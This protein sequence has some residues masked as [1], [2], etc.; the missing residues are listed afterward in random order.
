MV[1][2]PRSVAASEANAAWRMGRCAACGSFVASLYATAAMPRGTEITVAAAPHALTT[3][4][5]GTFQVTFDGRARTIDGRKVAGAHAILWGARGE[6][7]YA[8]LASASATLPHVSCS[9]TAEVWGGRLA[10][11]LLLQTRLEHGNRSARVA[12]DNLNVIRY[13][14]SSLACPMMPLR[15]AR[16]NAGG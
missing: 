1:A 13:C 14:A 6:Q 16:H 3:G 5:G 11:L 8:Q 12:G 15:T 10:M 4:G 9:Q 7:A 2:P